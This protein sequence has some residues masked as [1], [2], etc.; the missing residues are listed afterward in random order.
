MISKDDLSP[1][2]N[3]IPAKKITGPLGIWG[4]GLAEFDRSILNSVWEFG[5]S[6]EVSASN[7]SKMMSSFL[8]IS[9]GNIPPEEI[10]GRFK[11]AKWGK[12]R[13]WKPSIDFTMEM[14]C[15]NS[16][17]RKKVH[18]KVTTRNV[19]KHFK[20]CTIIGGFIRF[21]DPHKCLMK[22]FPAISNPWRPPHIIKFQDAPCQSPPSSITINT[23]LRLLWSPARFPPS[24]M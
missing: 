15:R 17:L 12:S 11:F 24:G 13:P 20:L 9:E 3:S 1:R 5:M 16:A 14:E 23:L 18:A 22:W 21:F 4:L 7:G 19:P 6:Q 2:N 8:R 10:P